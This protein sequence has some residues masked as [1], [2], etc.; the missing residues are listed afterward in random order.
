MSNR[1]HVREKRGRRRASHERDARAMLL[2]L[3]FTQRSHQQILFSSKQILQHLS[4]FLQSSFYALSHFFLDGILPEQ[5][6][7]NIFVFHF[8]SALLF[9]LYSY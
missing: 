7:A 9:T 5:F 2:S 4:T 6:K 1:I 8:I 3:Q